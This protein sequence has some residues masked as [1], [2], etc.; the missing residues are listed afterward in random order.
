MIRAVEKSMKKA[1]RV[2]KN[3]QL[4]LAGSIFL[5]AEGAGSL[6]NIVFQLPVWYLVTIECSNCVHFTHS[7]YS[8]PWVNYHCSV[9]WSRKWETVQWNCVRVHPYPI[10]T[11][12]IPPIY[13]EYNWR[14][15]SRTAAALVNSYRLLEGYQ[16]WLPL[17]RVVKILSGKWSKQGDCTF[18][19]SIYS[20]AW[21]AFRYFSW[22]DGV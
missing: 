16:D 17:R 18:N 21:C 5:R 9:H 13:R 1:V 20:G 7:V 4:A 19:L 15:R 6:K 10:S 14:A 2:E 3:N 11:S 22:I 8:A 12:S